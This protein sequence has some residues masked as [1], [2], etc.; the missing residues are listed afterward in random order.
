[1]KARQHGTAVIFLETDLEKTPPFDETSLSEIQR[2]V[3]SQLS[4]R[5][6]DKIKA[7]YATRIVDLKKGECVCEFNSED[8]VPPQ[9]AI[10]SISRYL[11]SKIREYYA[12]PK[13]RE[14]LEK[15]RKEQSK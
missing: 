6:K 7:G 1:M 13:N 5:E 15:R 14:E 2:S 8:Y 11:A 10:D 12:D 4:T 9:S 3:F